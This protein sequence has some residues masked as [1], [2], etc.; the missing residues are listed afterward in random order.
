[1][2]LHDH[3]RHPD[4]LDDLPVDSCHWDGCRDGVPAEDRQCYHAVGWPDKET[5]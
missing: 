3:D 1:M 4:C 5:T 2:L